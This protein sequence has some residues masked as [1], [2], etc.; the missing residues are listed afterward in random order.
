[1]GGRKYFEDQGGIEL[2]S[3]IKSFYFNY[4]GTQSSL[5]FYRYEPEVMLQIDILHLDFQKA[6]AEVPFRKSLC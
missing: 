3:L 5:M 1:M 6:F 2:G 4:R